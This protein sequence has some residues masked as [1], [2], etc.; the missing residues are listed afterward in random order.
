[1]ATAQPTGRIKSAELASAL[2]AGALG[3]GLALLAPGWLRAYAAWL[4]FGGIV[5]H[6]IG[7]TLKYRFESS[8]A[9]PLWWECALFWLCW[10][11]LVALAAWLAVVAAVR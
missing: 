6:G 10:A 2:G 1:M 7:M 3:A 11:C 4:L 8:D 9:P 5:V